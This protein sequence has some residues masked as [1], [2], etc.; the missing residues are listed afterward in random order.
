[1]D[2]GP[3]NQSHCFFPIET[4]SEQIKELITGAT[5]AFPFTDID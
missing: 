2:K 1:M 5:S 3:A 4:F